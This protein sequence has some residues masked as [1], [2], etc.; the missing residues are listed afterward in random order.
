M[1]INAQKVVSIALYIYL[2]ISPFVIG[3]LVYS[4]HRISKEN[5]N[6]NDKAEAYKAMVD[7][8]EMFEKEVKN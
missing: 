6:L 4:N 5:I 1:S 2:A 3:Y 8:Q 7:I